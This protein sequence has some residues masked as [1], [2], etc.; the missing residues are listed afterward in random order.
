MTVVRGLSLDHVGLFVPDIGAAALALEPMG[1]A[2]T[3]L[4]PQQTAGG[5]GEPPAPAGTSNRC[6][7]LAGGY[8]EVLTATGDTPVARQ[9]RAA[10]A[11]YTGL[12]LIAFGTADA[13]AEHRRLKKAGYEPL[14][15]VPLERPVATDG[16][17]GVARFSVVRVPP[18]TMAE[19]RIQ[20]VQQR[21]PELV[22]Q[23]RFLAHRN[24][25]AALVDVLVCVEDPGEA[26]QRYARFAGRPAAGVAPRRWR[27]V[28][29]RGRV[30][31]MDPTA[32]AAALPGV[33]APALPFIAAVVLASGDLDITRAVLAAGGVAHRD[34]APGIVQ[35]EPP[36][37]LGVTVVFSAL[38]A[39]SPWG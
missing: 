35:V 13:A 26:V 2:A 29:D 22:W 4:T 8:I 23:P 15:L 17:E 14:P 5:P 7:M 34:A 39:A 1:F 36:P 18:G 25:A 20:F 21:T 32:L 9:L 27:L 38:D 24:R 30:S 19:G 3:P 28:T 31:F 12:H 11:R 10:L 37:A 16:G 6:I 33:A